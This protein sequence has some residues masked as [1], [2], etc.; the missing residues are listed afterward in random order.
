MENLLRTIV[1]TA[2]LATAF[3]V[4]PF[5]AHTNPLKQ[6][7]FSDRQLYQSAVN[8]IN[9]GRVS[10]FK[11]KAEELDGYVLAPYL[12]YHYLSH[13]IA[14]TSPQ[15]MQAFLSANGDL[16]VA[17]LTFSR[18]LKSLGKRRQW[19]TYL[20]NYQAS[21]DAASQCYYLRALYGTGKR[22]AALDQVEPLWLAPKSQPKACDPIFDVWRGTDRFNEDVAWQRFHEAIQANERTFARY[23]LRFFSGGNRRA[24]DWYWTLHTE[25]SRLHRKQELR[26]DSPKYRQVIAHGLRRLSRNKPEQAWQL[27]DHYQD[28]HS[29]PIEVANRL[30][31]DL[32][33]A[34]AKAGV[35]PAA[36]WRDSIT[37]VN[38][39]TA[40]VDAAVKRQDWSQTLFWLE[41]LPDLD[42]A[43][44]R[45]QY[46]LGRSLVAV[47][48]T[49]ERAKLTFQALANERHYYGFLAAREIGSA[50][51]LNAQ[52][53]SAPVAGQRDAELLQRF[54]GLARAVELFA[55]GDALNA[56]REWNRVSAMMNRTERQHIA[57]IAKNIGQLLVAIRTATDADAMDDVELRF[58]R[59]YT[60]HYA[61]AAHV[62][63]LDINLLQ[64][65]TRQESAFNP[66]ARSSAGA[67]GLMQLMPAT[68]AMVAKRARMSKPLTSDLYQ[69][70][71]NIRLGS[72]HLA[73]L[74]DRY[75]GNRPFAIAAYN[76]G[77]RRVDRWIKENDDLPMDIWIETIPFR[78]TRNYVKNVLAF[79]LVYGMLHG[80][81]SQSI[82]SANEAFGTQS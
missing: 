60:P 54:P 19:K 82:L 1:V 9:R 73:W 38:D 47:G 15:D 13:H 55:V 72:F 45:W 8:D 6:A 70:N 14:Q 52:A 4:A 80:Q 61:E 71:T 36:E 24:A 48:D 59:N 75:D 23:L 62:T 46:W 44:P 11:R 58:P 53:M 79:T 35:F 57:H 2:C 16:P 39:I 74:I 29:F 67:R 81:V 42:R 78:E 33:I 17:R 31:I 7:S 50:P 51:K 12:E 68:A 63:G 76:A 56:R 27:W 26:Q 21:E 37:Q 3:F 69:P 30:N 25:P 10:A 43:E 66:R 18:W 34:R 64:A 65:I 41:R 20:Q 49:S 40:L 77:E 5:Y 22:T 32:A 28:S